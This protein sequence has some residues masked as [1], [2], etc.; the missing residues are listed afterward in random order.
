MIFLRLFHQRTCWYS[1]RWLLF[2][3]TMLSKTQHFPY[4]STLRGKHLKHE[5]LLISVEPPTKFMIQPYAENKPNDH[6]LLVYEGG[7]ILRRLYE[8]SSKYTGNENISQR[9]NHWG[10]PPCCH[11]ILHFFLCLIHADVVTFGCRHIRF[12]PCNDF[13]KR[14]AAAKTSATTA[15]EVQTIHR[16]DPSLSFAT[17]GRGACGLYVV[18]VPSII[19]D[20]IMPRCYQNVSSFF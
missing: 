8:R 10:S 1:H 3:Y 6:H 17:S 4:W 14:D 15:V 20:I 12:L 11:F 9:L 18:V 13:Q 7:N 19:V 2:S 5:R 16:W